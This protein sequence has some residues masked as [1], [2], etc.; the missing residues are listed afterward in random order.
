MVGYNRLRKYAIT[1]LENQLSD[2]LVYHGIHHTY[3]VLR[4]VNFLITTEKVSKHD[5]KLLRV[6]AIYHDI[7]FIEVYRD[8]EEK[9]VSILKAKMEELGCDKKDFEKIA[10]M[11]MA[12]KIPQS[13]KNILEKII[14]DA[15]LFY[16]GKGKKQYYE[17][18]GTLCEELLDY[19]FIESEEQWVNIQI[20]FLSNHSYHTNYARKNLQKEK[21]N[22]VKE[23]EKQKNS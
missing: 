13:P 16:L 2:D 10:G 12:T 17:I 5:A 19:K 20:S 9:G 1:V 23:L 7:G 18:S 14:C 3:D 8:H 6:A 11:I 22:R 15:D 21:E 4:Y